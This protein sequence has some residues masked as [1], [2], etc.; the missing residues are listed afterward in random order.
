MSLLFVVL[1]LYYMQQHFFSVKFEKEQSLLSPE[2][3]ND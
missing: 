3:I 2:N 1:A